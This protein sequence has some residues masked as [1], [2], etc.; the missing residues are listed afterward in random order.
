MDAGMNVASAAGGPALQPPFALPERCDTD[1][2]E[3]YGF[4]HTD[5]GLPRWVTERFVPWGVIYRELSPRSAVFVNPERT[6]VDR[7]AG[8][9]SGTVR[10]VR[11]AG[12]GAFWWFK[13]RGPES[14]AD[15]AFICE[16]AIDAMS[17]YFLHFPRFAAP[18][19]REGVMGNA[20]YCAVGGAADQ[21][22]IDCIRSGMDAAGCKTIIAMGNDDAGEQCRRRNQDCPS[23]RPQGK[24]WNEDLK[25]EQKIYQGRLAV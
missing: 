12:P 20:L 14:N 1:I 16:S 6:F 23:I 11:R 24:T 9:P 2:G 22:A 8:S 25:A 18:D 10:E 7:Y 13:P 3:L 4:L 19:Y 17:L 21:A 5:Y 15:R